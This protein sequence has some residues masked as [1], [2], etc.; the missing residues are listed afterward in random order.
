[1]WEPQKLDLNQKSAFS[2]QGVGAAQWI[3]GLPVILGPMILY[4][5]F[6]IWGTFYM[7]MAAFFLMGLLGIVFR[8]R[9]ISMS[10]KRAERLKY[11][12]GSSFRSE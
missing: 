5:P 12:I 4:I 2:F 10:A 9:L 1:M 8:N 11:S 3:M 7:A 6:A